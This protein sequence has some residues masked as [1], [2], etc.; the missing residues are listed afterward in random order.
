V[1]RQRRIAEGS[2]TSMPDHS[3]TLYVPFATQSQSC[4]IDTSSHLAMLGYLQT[5]F[6]R[7][8]VRLYSHGGMV[9]VLLEYTLIY[10]IGSAHHRQVYRVASAFH[11]GTFNPILE[12]KTI[13][14]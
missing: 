9:S 3:F 5:V 14:K 7:P 8:P 13:G 10:R 11:V 12:K 4:V 2:V 1:T 6:R